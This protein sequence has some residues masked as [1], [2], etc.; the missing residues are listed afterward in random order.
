MTFFTVILLIFFRPTYRR[1]LAERIAEKDKVLNQSIDTSQINPAL[2][3][4]DV[5]AESQVQV[6]RTGSVNGI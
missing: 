3:D 4:R 1:L 5:H 6:R 2:E